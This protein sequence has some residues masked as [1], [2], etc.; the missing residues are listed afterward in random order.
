MFGNLVTWKS[1]KQ[2]VIAKTFQYL[3]YKLVA[4][5]VQNILKKYQEQS[6]INFHFNFHI[7]WFIS[8]TWAIDIK[9]QLGIVL[10]PPPSTKW[11]KNDIKY[12][13]NIFFI[14]GAGYLEYTRNSRNISVFWFLMIQNPWFVLFL[15]TIYCFQKVFLWSWVYGSRTLGLHLFICYTRTT[16][17]GCITCWSKI[18]LCRFILWC[19]FRN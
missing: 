1:N 5:H 2:N 7:F 4:N 11:S 16:V 6:G 18:I 17:L 13:L 10:S 8:L 15:H 3:Y 9:Y 19:N 14:V 12:R